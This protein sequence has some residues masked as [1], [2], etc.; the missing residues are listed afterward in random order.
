MHLLVHLAVVPTGTLSRRFRSRCAMA[1]NKGCAA[2]VVE[3]VVRARGVYD[4]LGMLP[5]ATISEMRKVYRRTCLLVHPDKCKVSPLAGS[6]SGWPG[7]RRNAQ[8]C[9]PKALRQP[10]SP[11]D[12]LI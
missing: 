2:A 6:C 11:G 8:G 5:G 9:R 1:P 12:V 7:L 3:R 4:A 10:R